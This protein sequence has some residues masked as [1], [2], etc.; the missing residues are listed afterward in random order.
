MGALKISEVARRS[1]FPATTLRYYEQ[2]GLLE[3]ARTAAG[4]RMYDEDETLDRL[5][6]ID[7]ARR[8]G[9]ALGDI[10]ELV[11]LWSGGECEPVQHRLRAL[12]A[13]RSSAV[14]DQ[15]GEL[16]AFASQLRAI[17]SR[18]EQAAPLA[19]CGPGCG[20]ELEAGTDLLTCT[21]DAGEVGPRLEQWRDVVARSIGRESL[22]SGV[23]LRFPR[24]EALL[25]RLAQLAVAETGCCSFFGMRLTVDADA[26]WLEVTAPEAARHL[27]DQLL[28]GS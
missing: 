13:A 1:G 6:F 15:L 18:L 16:Q 24:E 26:A 9:F 3:P 4:Y 27:V 23:R 7:R 5:A 12:L 19:R 2:V 11:G 17:R 20:C 22:P 21:L 10:A 25:G 8:M 14:D 28:D